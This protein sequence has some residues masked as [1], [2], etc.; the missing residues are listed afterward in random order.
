MKEAEAV[1]HKLFI[2]AGARKTLQSLSN[3]S[4]GRP[5]QNQDPWV[6][7]I[8]NCNISCSTLGKDPLPA[9]RHSITERDSTDWEESTLNELNELRVLQSRKNKRRCHD[10]GPRNDDA[11]L[12][13]LGHQLV[14]V[15][16]KDSPSAGTDSLKVL[17]YSYLQVHYGSNLNDFCF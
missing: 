10:I 9:L 5:L 16:R 2:N 11:W 1:Y 15:V 14:I 6:C 7:S 4:A 8:C 12:L 13:Y 17:L 3:I